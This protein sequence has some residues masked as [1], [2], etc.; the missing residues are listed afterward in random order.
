MTELLLVIQ[1]LHTPTWKVCLSVGV[2]VALVLGLLLWPL[3][4]TARE[5]TEKGRHHTVRN[6]DIDRATGQASN[7]VK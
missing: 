6:N 2:L 3:V 5:D 1:G 7:D 4:W